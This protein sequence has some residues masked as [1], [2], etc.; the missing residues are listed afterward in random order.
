[1]RQLTFIE[2]GRFEW[3]DVSAPQVSDPRHAVVRP[4]AVARCDLDLYIALGA[5]PPRNL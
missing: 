5:A 3:R 4:L 2:R 1:M